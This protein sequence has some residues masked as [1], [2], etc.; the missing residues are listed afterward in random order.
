[1]SESAAAIAWRL[2]PVMVALLLMW[3][4][5]A[6]N[7]LLLHGAWLIYGV[8]A[9]DPTGF[10]P[11]LLFAP[12]LHLGLAH[13]V[14]NTAPFAVLGGL[15]A[16]QSPF[17]FL[18]LSVVGAAIG[19]A[20]VWL[21]APTGSVTIGASGLVFTYFGWLITRAVRERSMLA[22]GIGLVTLLL[23]GGILWGL[24]PLQVGISWQG[25]LGGLIGGVGVARVWPITRPAPVVGPSPALV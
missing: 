5:T 13:L 16:L 4:A 8:R 11:D 6:I 25:H 22:I 9:H 10:W 24:S 21:L 20:V 18:L 1:V 2:A 14:A 12:F 7:L 19:A 3:L 15:I 23:Y 17:R